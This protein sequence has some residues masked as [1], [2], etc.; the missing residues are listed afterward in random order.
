MEEHDINEKLDS[1]E[2]SGFSKSFKIYAT[3]SYI[4]SATTILCSLI[5]VNRIMDGE[6]IIP[7]EGHI[8][9]AELNLGVFVVC[10][11]WFIISLLSML[12]VRKMQ[13]GKKGGFTLYL[14]VNII[15]VLPFILVML[16][17][18]YSPYILSVVV[19]SIAFMVVFGKEKKH[20]S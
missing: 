19:G 7:N 6:I 11:V 14:I 20:M 10:C 5:L 15:F 12:G 1:V 16:L 9:G 13:K 3:L 18:G 2:S 4:G 8:S 17:G